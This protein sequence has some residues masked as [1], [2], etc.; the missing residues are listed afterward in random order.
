MCSVELTCKPNN[1][2]QVSVR[3]ARSEDAG[4]IAV[5]CQ[6]LGF[7]ASQEEVQRRLN[8]IQQDESHTVYVAERSDGH[9]I[10][11]VHVCVRQL[12]VANQRAEIEGLV[13]EEGYRRCG[14][15]RLLMEQAE[16]WVQI[17][18][19]GIVHLRSNVVRKEARPF[20]EGI[21][22]RNVKTQWTFRKEL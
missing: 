12:V 20:Y 22:Y 2:N 6:N 16:R 5:L 21:G 13:V 18:G 10:G 8:Q 4:R 17:K 1:S 11:W 14:V 19:C 3:L 15:G 9:V 7:S